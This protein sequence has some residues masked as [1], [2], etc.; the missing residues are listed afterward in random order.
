M[1]SAALTILPV[2]LALAM[3]AG[4]E[5]E[6]ARTVSPPAARATYTEGQNEWSDPVNV[7][8]PISSSF[9]EQSPVLSADGRSL[10][11]SSNRPGSLGGNDLWVSHRGCD[12]CPWETPINLGPV[13]NSVAGDAGPSLSVDGRRLFFNSARE[14]GRGLN[15]IYM[16]RRANPADDFG[17]EEPVLLGPEVST[18]AYEHAPT[19]IQ[20]GV[21]AGSLYFT[22]G[23]TNTVGNDIYVIEV[24]HDGGLIGQ[25]MLVSDLSDPATNDAMTTFSVNGKEVIFASDRPPPHVG[26]TFWRATRKHAKAPWST[27]ENLVEV[28]SLGRGGIHPSLSH[29]GRTLFFA[30]GRP[31]TL[32][33]LDIWMS[34]RRHRDQ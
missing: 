23:V 15:D 22:R 10:Y 7:G 18:A 32:G 25:A 1:K 6:P 3:I 19:Y 28:T 24:T 8:A 27:P 14:G 9:L 21:D 29:D 34:T 17:W 13:V 33:G 2:V 31:G 4:C 26:F 30:S 20:T 16:S 12:H 5:M 11:F